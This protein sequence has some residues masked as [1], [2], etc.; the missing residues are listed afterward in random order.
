M[1]NKIMAHITK[2][3]RTF[4]SEGPSNQM[5]QNILSYRWE[6]VKKEEVSKTFDQIWEPSE[7][8]AVSL[9]DA[10]I[11]NPE[12]VKVDMSKMDVP[13]AIMMKSHDKEISR[14]EET[15]VML[16]LDI[17]RSIHSDL[18]NVRLRVD[19]GSV[20]QADGVFL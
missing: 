14:E 10:T 1:L 16:Q 7:K 3:F 4:R 9:P 2:P 11:V 6:T 5:L 19:N 20:R 15:T 8:D 17:L 12:P 18:H 13:P